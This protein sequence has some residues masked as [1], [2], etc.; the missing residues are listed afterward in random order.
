MIIVLR[1]T[2]F[3]RRV[4]A[5]GSNKAIARLCGIP[6]LRLKALMYKVS[7]LFYGL[8]GLMQLSRLQQ[9]DPMVAVGLDVDVIAAVVMV[10][11]V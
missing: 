9:G 3:G 6:T 8:A 5:L 1:C 4:Y 7:G 11:R 2:V 10:V